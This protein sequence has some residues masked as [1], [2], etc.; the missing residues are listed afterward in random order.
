MSN[1]A[2]GKKSG[3][4]GAVDLLWKLAARRE[5]ALAVVIALI[6]LGVSLRNHDF[7]SGPIVGGILVNCV[8]PAIIACGVMLVIVTGEIDISV[9]SSMGFLTAVMG[10]LMSRQQY[11]QWAQWLSHGLK[12]P[13]DG[14]PWPAAGIEPFS[15]WAAIVLTLALGALI[16][17]V[18]GIFVTIVRVPSIIVTLGM[19]TVLKGF[20][21]MMMKDG[22]IT[23]LPDSFHKIGTGDV[24]G[25]HAE[26]IAAALHMMP[27]SLHLMGRFSIW[28]AVAVVLLTFAMIKLTPI[29]RRIYAVG[30]NSHA[31]ALAGVSEKW[32]KIFAFSFTGFLVAVAAV[33]T[34]VAVFDNGTGDG[35]E[36][37]VVTCVVVG[38]VSISGGTGTVLGVM[39]GVVLLMMQK[40][41]LIF[42]KLSEN[43]SNWDK[44]IQGALIL[45]AV[46]VD[47]LASKRAK[48]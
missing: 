35:M 17:L 2:V 30:S 33:V 19:L 5:I 13:E 1:L 40:T 36:L 47:H 16:G 44:A 38:G 29:G 42:L 20:T 27:E 26:G 21:I 34:Q 37:L 25:S 14:S 41:V 23:D 31:A 6:F 22:N 46:L 32:V 9:G 11:P 43:A 28:I 45:G 15:V 24:L 48:P 12:M 8:Q 4:S 10:I 3:N 39:F 18:N 7:F